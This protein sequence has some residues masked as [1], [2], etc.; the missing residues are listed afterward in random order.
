[1]HGRWINSIYIVMQQCNVSIPLKLFLTTY[2]D[3]THNCTWNLIF[4][5]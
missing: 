1:M 4:V 3:P 2:R 5:I